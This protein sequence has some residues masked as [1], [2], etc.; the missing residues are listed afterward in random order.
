[1][2]HLDSLN[3]IFV[4]TDFSEYSRNA[5]DTAVEMGSKHNAFVTMAYVIEPI[6]NFAVE[7]H[8]IT[9]QLEEQAKKRFEE[10]RSEYQRNGYEKSSLKGIIL[11]G[12][13]TVSL[14]DQISRSNPD[15]VV[16]GSKGQTGL[17]KVIYGSVAETLM[18]RSSSPVLVIPKSEK[19]SAFDRVLFTTAFHEN[20]PDNLDSL[21]S[22][23]KP[24][25]SDIRLVHVAPEP[26]FETD[27]KIRG[28]VDILKNELMLQKNPRI[29]VVYNDHFLD[30]I[31]SYAKENR[32][33]L[34][35]V[36]RYT[37]GL[38]DALFGSS[39]TKELAHLH[40][41]LILVLTDD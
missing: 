24:Y 8:K 33:E 16:I 2:S 12:K 26:G 15:L 18:L 30:G 32:M 37:K 3:H 5:I 14:L 40:N 1:M 7:V 20:D 41:A 39:H 25:N 29:D 10:I 6:Y 28:F 9:E 27:I 22:F 21:R 31:A 23:L 19:R 11:H 34:I 13:I 35:V 36:N 38:M 17:K 4:P